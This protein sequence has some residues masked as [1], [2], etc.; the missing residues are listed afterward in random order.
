MTP[1]SLS[2]TLLACVLSFA[3]ASA[4]P[5]VA[6]VSSWN[7]QVTP[8]G[9]APL[10]DVVR[11][12]IVGPLDAGHLALLGRAERRAREAG[13]LLLVRI[14][15]PGG[16]VTRMRQIAAA[17]D[18]AAQSGTQVATWVDDD[19]L[20]AGVWITI[21]GR[22]VLMAPTAT[23]G[24]AQVVQFGPQ[25]MQPAPEKIQ[26]AYR[27]WV[28]GWAETHGRSQE[29]AEAMIDERIVVR[30]IRD[31]AGVV[32]LM[33]GVEWDDLVRQGKEPELV[34][35]VSRAGEMLTLTATEA[36]ALGF[37]DAIVAD[38]GEVL[39]K[40]GH[41]GGRIER[42]ERTRSEDLLSELYRLRLVLL[43][44]GLLLGYME[45]K[46]PGFGVAGI[47]SI[48]VF[49]LLFA[50]HYLV[51]LAEMP[52]L[53]LAGGG[54]ALIA[55]ELFVVPG[56]VW[57][58]LVGALCLIGALVATQ[59]GPGLS[60][61]SA[62]DRELL[63]DAAFEL[64]LTAALALVGIWLISRFLP[65]TPI[66]GRLVLAGVE[67][68][69]LSVDAADALPESRVARAAQLGA[70][71][72]AL[73]ALR[74]VGKVALD[75]DPPGID[76]EAS[77]PGALLAPGTR[78]RVTAVRAGRLEVE[79]LVTDAPGDRAAGEHERV[80]RGHEPHGT[81]PLGA[82]RATEKDGPQGTA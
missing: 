44:V 24:A 69:A 73:T 37:A 52:H 2:W 19:A 57:F 22:P 12:D 74:P 15:T 82:A 10:P 59:V 63:I 43:F 23:I 46:T 38:E 16:E 11:F 33:S 47:L 54:L 14:D 62:W 42:L 50:G 64:A 36:V 9:E 39:A 17:L 55:I 66:V 56:F 27:A 28:R 3:L 5:R 67:G 29:L 1:R 8:D 26:S 79:A 80:E 31:E 65:K 58:G 30:R 45:L 41:A 34:S 72:R 68:H 60:L 40:L 21:V 61:S 25:G 18:S 76:H 71:G 70:L 7:A 35:T 6:P 13:A 75:G 78:V 51:G 49:T 20:S 53:V 77:A 81:P 4:E 32:R 48:V